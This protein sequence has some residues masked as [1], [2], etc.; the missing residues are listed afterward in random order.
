MGKH[1]AVLLAVILAFGFSVYMF[2]QAVGPTSPWTVLLLFF[3]FLGIAKFLEPIYMLKLPAGIREVRSWE[4][5]GKAYAMLGVPGFGALLRN[6]PL[7][8]LN[9]TV[10]VSRQRRD[11]RLISRQV[12]SAEAIHFWSA[13]VL[14]PYLA[15]CLAAGRWNVLGAFLAVEILGNAYPIMHLRSV[16]GRIDRLVRRGG[17]ARASY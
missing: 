10:Y 6:T 17:G 13:W 16:R 11:P 8:L 3:C 2:Q 7:R 4:I 14:V 15:W 1:V 12:E 9:T 5:R